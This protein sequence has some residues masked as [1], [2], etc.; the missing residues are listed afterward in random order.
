[1]FQDKEQQAHSNLIQKRFVKT[2][3]VSIELKR[4]LKKVSHF[5]YKG[6]VFNYVISKMIQDKTLSL[7]KEKKFSIKTLNGDFDV[8][9]KL[10]D[11]RYSRTVDP[12]LGEYIELRLIKSGMENYVINN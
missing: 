9:Y 12:V 10:S 6:S 8:I 5:F 2:L 1:M 3:D 4:E 7:V 11:G